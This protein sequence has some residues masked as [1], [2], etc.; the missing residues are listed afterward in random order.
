MRN[1]LPLRFQGGRWV[2]LLAAG[3][4][5]MSA[6]ATVSGAAIAQSESSER[7]AEATP[8]KV[9]V[10]LR[11]Q[12]P[13]VIKTET[14]DGNDW[15]GIGVQLWREVAEDL[16][17][18]YEW[19]EISADQEIAQ[20]QNGGVDIVV[21]A[22]ATPEGEQQ[23]DFTQ[24][25]YVS[26]LGIAQPRQRKLLDIVGSVL[27]P[28]FLKVCLWL[29]LLLLVVGAIVWLFERNKN[30][31]MYATRPAQGLWDSFWWAGVTLTTIGYGDKAPV[32]V[33]GRVVALLWMLVAIGLISS[34][35]ATITSVV[36]QDTTGQLSNPAMLKSL[37]VGTIE[38]SNAAQVLQQQQIPFQSFSSPQ[39]GLSAVDNGELDA[40]I[41]DAALM[42]YL[43]QNEF[44]NRLAIA[45]SDLQTGHHA[46]AMAEDAPLLES[47]NAEVIAAQM[48]TDWPSLL[49][50]FLPKGGS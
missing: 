11:H 39:D 9:T 1:L 6:G 43:N 45:S 20:L 33:G 28:R 25:Y 50:R 37:T 2:V 48:E 23:V 12:P 32:T 22:I 40:F 46:F 47:I 30:D 41:Y 4:L 8:S 16:D 14:Q 36:S 31:D 26:S 29:S 3:L 18:Q 49:E 7:S 27:S 24:S 17:I 38:D 5:V 13:F 10:G 21:S 15:D 34:L 42:S 19:K 35:T 44:S